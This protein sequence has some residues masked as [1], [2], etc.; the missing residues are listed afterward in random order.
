MHVGPA[1]QSMNGARMDTSE[2]RRQG[3][4]SFLPFLLF[5]VTLVYPSSSSVSLLHSVVL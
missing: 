2:G 5:S 4:A 3:R 1:R